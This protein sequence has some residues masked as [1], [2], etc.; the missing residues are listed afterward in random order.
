MEDTGFSMYLQGENNSA[1][2][3]MLINPYQS[4]F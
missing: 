2:F 3:N 4:N 1:Y